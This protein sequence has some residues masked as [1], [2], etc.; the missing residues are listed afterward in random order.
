MNNLE[1]EIAQLQQK[2]EEKKNLLEQQG[3]IVE[4]K[5]LVSSALN[6]MFTGSTGAT[7]NVGATVSSSSQPVSDMGTS[8]LDNID[9]QTAETISLLIQKLPT[10]GIVKVVAEAE[11]AGPYLVDVLH[12]ALV[13][14]MYEELV[15][16]GFIKAK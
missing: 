12:D 3:G 7:P 10:I 6:E 2:I 9:E 14:K 5:E 16:R 13:D 8:Y 1:L 15:Q 4:E 11:L